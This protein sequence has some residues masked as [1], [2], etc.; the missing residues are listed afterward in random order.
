MGERRSGRRRGWPL[1]ALLVAW[2]LSV[3]AQPYPSSPYPA[4]PSQGG[5]YQGGPSQGSPYPGSAYPGSA[6][7]GSAYPGSTH[8][9]GQFQGSSPYPSPANV[10]GV[11]PQGPPPGA[12]VPSPSAAV[13][14]PYPPGP[15]PS[16]SP[17]QGADPGRGP[18]PGG[19]GADPQLASRLQSMVAQEKRDLGVRAPNELHAGAMHGPT[20]AEIP[21]GQ[22]ITTLG[23]HALLGRGDVRPLVFDVLGA[24]EMLPGALPAVAAAAAGQFSDPLQQ[25]FGQYL[26]QATQGN[27]DTPLVFYCQGLQCWMSYNAAMRAIRLGY[28][29][30]LWYRGGLEAWK[31]AGLPVQ[32]AGMPPASIAPGQ[33]APGSTRPQSPPPSGYPPAGYPPAG[34]PPAGY[35]PSGASGGG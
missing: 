35:P 24:G 19:M 27:R 30:V 2:S 32:A 16:A 7:P 13:P 5:P 29:N 10:P 17:G 3:A 11:H 23:L 12:A 4:S 15:M 8:Q 33:G 20:P 1:P 6:Y 34:Y 28:R 14:T 18:L 21:G 25:Q 9:G 22:L 26:S 31:Y